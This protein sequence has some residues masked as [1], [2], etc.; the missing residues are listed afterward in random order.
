MPS[1]TKRKIFKIGDSRA[2]TIPAFLVDEDSDEAT[3]AGNRLMI[4]DPRGEI[5]EGELLEFLESIEPRFWKWREEKME[6]E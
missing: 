3:V 6:A 4:T 2:I 5:S 1:S